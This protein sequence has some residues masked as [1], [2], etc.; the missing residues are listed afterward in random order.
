M[1]RL[2]PYRTC[3]LCNEIV[4]EPVSEVQPTHRSCSLRNVMG[5]I[6]HLMAHEYWCVQQGDA[7][8]GLTYRQSA[9]M[10]DAYVQIV[11]IA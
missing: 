6:G 10:V 5:G 1:A 8:A 3:I 11:G 9:R 7:D 4:M 2:S